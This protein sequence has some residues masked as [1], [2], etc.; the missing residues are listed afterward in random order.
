[1]FVNVKK[2]LLTAAVLMAAAT[3]Y[4]APS[5][6]AA[7]FLAAPQGGTAKAACGRRGCF[8]IKNGRWTWRPH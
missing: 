6:K 3:A 5:A 1:M 8:S 7:G 4:D 2:A